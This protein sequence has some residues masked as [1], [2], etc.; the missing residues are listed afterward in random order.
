MLGFSNTDLEMFPEFDFS[1]PSSSVDS[2]YDPKQ[3]SLAIQ[4]GR[5]EQCLLRSWL[6]MPPVKLVMLLTSRISTILKI[7]VWYVHPKL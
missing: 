7:L 4:Y 2:F 5:Y 3:A 1:K 6:F